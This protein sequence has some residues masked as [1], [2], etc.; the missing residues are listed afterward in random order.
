MTFS[1]VLN[2]SGKIVIS[3]SDG[4]LR[5]PCNRFL[6]CQR[7]RQRRIHK[8]YLAFSP[9]NEHFVTGIVLR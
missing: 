5:Q 3:Y 2:I 1:K 8:K 6:E 4:I 9:V 7:S